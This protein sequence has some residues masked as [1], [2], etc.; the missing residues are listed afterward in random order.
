MRLPLTFAAR[1]GA[2][3]VVGLLACTERPAGSPNS[4]LQ[5]PVT[6]TAASAGDLIIYESRRDAYRRTLTARE[7]RG[8]NIEA[9]ERSALRELESLLRPIVGDFSAPWARRR[10]RMNQTTLTPGSVDSGLPDGIL[11][12]SRDSTIQ[13]LV[14]TRDLMLSW[15][16]SSFSGDTTVSRDRAHAL[17]ND[18]VLTQIFDRDAAVY[19]Y[20]DIPVDS[21]LSGVVSAKLV[22]RSQD[23]APSEADEIMVSVA[24]GTRVFVID[25]PARDTLPIPLA[26]SESA[27]SGKAISKAFIDSAFQT[28]PQDTALTTKAVQNDDRT[29]A[30][31]RRCYGEAAPRH[32]RFQALV[33]QV[34]QLVESLPAR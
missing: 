16:D 15:L 5:V 26:C 33:A 13:V 10:G 3:S 29:N 4:K 8:E 19:S 24:R 11:Y 27:D 17:G 20:T 25:A 22:S 12:E 7:K 30:Q 2:L 31:F 23:Y 18:D 9:A 34:R 1:L 28:T 32:P 21:T 6:V 14:T